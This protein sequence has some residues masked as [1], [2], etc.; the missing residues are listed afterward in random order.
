MADLVVDDTHIEIVLSTLEQVGALRRT[1]R[2]PLSS[3]VSVRYADAARSGVS[4]IRAPGTAIPG[5]LKLGTW[6]SR[7]RKTFVATSGDRPGYIIDL[8]GE[9]LDRIVV[10]SPRIEAL[11]SLT[12]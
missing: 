2:V 4:G 8:T 10:A 5:G 3:V 1:V 7:S 9:S 6:R 11:D 12:S